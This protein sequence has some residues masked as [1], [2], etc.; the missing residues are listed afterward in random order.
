MAGL[1]LE[2]GDDIA[3]IE[4]ARTRLE[5]GNDPA[6]AVPGAGG[7]GE[8]GEAAHPVR[9]GLGAAHLEIVG[10]L[11]CKRVQRA[12][13]REAEDVVDAV[14]LAPGHGLRAA[15][16]AVSPEDDPGVRPVAADAAGPGA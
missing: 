9:A 1:A 8:G 13:A 12:I 16:V 15:V 11:V 2:R 3:G 10:H 7:V 6:F 14:L 4:A 5:P